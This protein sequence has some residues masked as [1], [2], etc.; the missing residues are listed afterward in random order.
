MTLRPWEP[1]SIDE[2]LKRKLGAQ[3][4][5]RLKEALK[6]YAFLL[7]PLAVLS[8][9]FFLPLLN[10][11]R[12]SVSEW[13]GL[14]DPRYVGLDNYQRLLHDPRFFRALK[15][16]LYYTLGV[17]PGLIIFP[18]LLALLINQKLP[19]IHVFRVMY[20][21]P[22]ITSMVI[23]GIA[24]R[25]VYNKYGILNYVLV[26]LG[27]FGDPPSWLTN[28]STALP[29][30]MVVTVWQASGWYMVVYWAGLK[31]VPRELT[32]AALI[33][34]A[35]PW[36]ATRYVTFP[37]LLPY[38]TL[39]TVVALIGSMRVFVEVFVMTRGGPAG[40]TDTLN[41]QLYVRAFR[42]LRFG[43]SAAIGVVLLVITLILSIATLRVL[44]R[45]YA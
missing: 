17:V 7:L 23:V 30:L 35:S 5:R 16:S 14:G 24:W 44:E 40:A 15:H 20:Y 42:D 45:R 12:L 38:V 37:M 10:T 27:L 11:F 19:G 41:L 6:A 36:Q 34:G 1:Q 22:Y 8:T 25:M 9:F 29:A 43:Y 2:R 4:V 31:T 13:A 28:T 18:F 33:D 26:S 32:E 3:R 21:I 39:N